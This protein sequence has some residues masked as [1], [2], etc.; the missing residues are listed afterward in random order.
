MFSYKRIFSVHLSQISPLQVSCTFYTNFQGVKIK[1]HT[2]L[3]LSVHL[4]R[5]KF[6]VKITSGKQNDPA[7]LMTSAFLIRKAVFFL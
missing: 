2:K 1:M 3:L 6:R 5:K 7:F 4:R